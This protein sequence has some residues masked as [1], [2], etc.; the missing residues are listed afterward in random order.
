MDMDGLAPNTLVN[1]VSIQKRTAAGIRSESIQATRASTSGKLSSSDTFAQ[2]SYVR[3]AV[4]LSNN[5][6][7]RTASRVYHTIPTSGDGSSGTNYNETSFEYDSLGRQNAVASAGGTITWDVFDRHDRAVCSYVGT[8]SSGATDDDPSAGREPCAI[9]S[10]SSSSSSSSSSG[11]SAAGNNM[12]LVSQRQ[13]DDGGCSSC[14]SG[15]EQLTLDIQYVNATTTRITEYFYDWRG[16]KEFDIPPAD[17][18]GRTVY[19]RTHY[20]NLDRVVRT[21]EYH[22][23]TVGD[24]ILIARTEN[25]IDDRGHT[26]H[27]RRYAVNAAT[28]EVGH[29]L[30]S[31]TWFDAAGN[32]IKQQAPGKRSFTKTVYDSLGRGIKQYVG[33][34]LSE[35]SCVEVEGSSSSSS[36]SSSPCGDYGT[37]TN[38][39]GDTIFE[40]TE[41]DYDDAGNVIETRLRRRHHDA[42]GT[43]QLTTPAGAQ[44]RARVS[45]AASYID[46]L[47]RDI[48]TANY[49][50]NGDAALTRSDTVPARSDTVL[51]SRSEYNDAGERFKSIDPAGKE[52]RTF[53]DDAG[54]VTKTIENYTDGDPTTGNADEDRT[55][56]FTYTP[57]GK[58]ATITAKQ[59]SL[60]ED[61]TTTYV[62]GTTLSDSDIARSDLLHA[63]I[64]PDSDDSTTGFQQV[65]SNGPDGVYDRIE[66]TGNRQGQRLSMKDQNGSIHQYEYNALGWPIHDRIT[67][68]ALDVDGAVR[69][70]STK[71]DLYG[72]V[73]QATSYDNAAVGSGNVVNQVV[74]QYNDFGLLDR[75]YQE[76]DGAKDGNTPYVG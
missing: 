51:V 12:V 38:V 73:E 31:Y 24:D 21:E 28:G 56:E 43:G 60:N 18:D 16:R 42:T 26:Y 62:Y 72:N 17:D 4:A 41:T 68:L 74:R 11:S 70:I 58:R 30:A 63:E 25:F 10:G 55:V 46:P 34:D 47:G 13:Y 5:V 44:P 54:R 39:L 1:P 71:Y 75:E 27:T 76:H 36:S 20:D 53:L 22:E 40:Q 59:Q 3:W 50:T 6:G 49:G 64:Y 65:F 35:S 2:S 29:Y 66:Y 57:D 61:Q 48:A 37:A 33:Y 9:V 67:T 15:G 23:Q 14:G 19:T 45:Y 7:Q 52:D 32:P 8:N 69:R